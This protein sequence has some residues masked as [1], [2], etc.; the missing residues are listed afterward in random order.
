MSLAVITTVQSASVTFLFT[1]CIHFCVRVR[2]LVF[3]V[4]LQFFVYLLALDIA[5]HFSLSSVCLLC[6]VLWTEI[7]NL[8]LM[9]NSLIKFFFYL[10]LL[11][12]VCVRD[13]RSFRF[14]S[15]LI[16]FCLDDKCVL[17]T[18][19]MLGIGNRTVNQIFRLL[20]WPMKH[21]KEQQ[22]NWWY[23]LLI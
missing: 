6:G 9:L 1:F 18:C 3:L 7:L 19:Y 13:Y 12:F 21:M 17:S 11:L 20:S 23:Y 16:V 8:F 15:S 22:S 10:T 2:F 4:D 5:N 14:Y